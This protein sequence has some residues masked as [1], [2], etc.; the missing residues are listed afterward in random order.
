MKGFQRFLLL[1]GIVQ[2][3]VIAYYTSRYLSSGWQERNASGTDVYSKSLMRN[4]KQ[5]F[6]GRQGEAVSE[7]L[8][9]FSDVM[10]SSI[11]E[12]IKAREHLLRQ[13]YDSQ[14]YPNG[15]LR[16]LSAQ[17][18][19][20]YFEEAKQ[21]PCIFT[22]VIPKTSLRKALDMFHWYR[23]GMMSNSCELLQQTVDKRNEGKPSYKPKC[24]NNPDISWRKMTNLTLYP[25]HVGLP[26]YFTIT[27]PEV[28]LGYVHV[29][30]NGIVTGNGDTF[31]GSSEIRIQRCGNKLTKS[32]KPTKITGHFTE[33]F[34]LSQYWGS[35]FFH[36]SIEN[37]PRIFPYLQFLLKYDSIKI[38]VKST[39]GLTKKYMT[40]IGIA[41]SRLVTGNVY[42][43]IVYLPN[44]SP[45]GRTSLLNIHYQSLFFRNTLHN[46]TNSSRNG[47]VL[48]QR[49]SKRWFKKHNAI[50]K[51]LQTLAQDYNLTAK[52]FSD[53]KLPSVGDTIQ[54]FNEAFLVVAP[55]GAGNSNL[56]FSEPGTVLVEGLCQPVVPAYVELTQSLAHRYYGIIYSKSG[57]TCFDYDVSD[58][59]PPAC[60]AI[61]ML[62]GE[63]DIQTG[64]CATKVR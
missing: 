16:I 1:M 38:H 55:H 23:Y 13:P 42:A 9:T 5:A 57:K 25:L 39:G 11:Q 41:E 30:K 52:V 20:N 63:K 15:T 6:P 3:I 31:C 37:L 64:V 47:I 49:S 43:D 46:V 27:G 33:V 40:Y 24:D 12:L 22:T 35:G 17:H 2:L 28:P 4:L 7:M 48:I 62:K 45:C 8:K 36:F 56:M 10:Q 54:L 59:I 58:I 53:K 29:I 51:S 61:A 60:Q 34:S 21:E 14:C 19:Q 44:G 26:K 18:D 32:K 50:L